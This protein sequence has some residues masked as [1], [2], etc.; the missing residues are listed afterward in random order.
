M[1]LTA[2][3]DRFS[4]SP[5]PNLFFFCFLNSLNPRHFFS[6]PHHHH[7]SSP[8]ILPS[9]HSPR[10]LAVLPSEIL[11]GITSLSRFQQNAQEPSPLFLLLRLPLKPFSSHNLTIPYTGCLVPTFVVNYRPMMLALVFVSVAGLLF[12]ES[13]VVSPFSIS[14]TT[15]ALFR[16]L[17][18]FY[19][20]IYGNLLC[21]V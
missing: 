2:T 14:E 4:T 21:F 3:R 19:L 9:I 5:K 13:M 6:T 1:Q 18:F 12:I 11:S 16:Y 15:L 17:L 7:A 10:H 20:R 8:P